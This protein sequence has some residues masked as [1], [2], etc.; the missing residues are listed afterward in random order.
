MKE[1]EVSIME[2]LERKV[3]IKADSKEAAEQLIRDE[4]FNSEH[5][6]D[7][8]DFKEVNFEVQ[9]ERKIN[10]DQLPKMDVLLIKPGMYPQA[11]QIGCELEDLQKVVG[12]DIEAIYPY[13]DLVAL[14]MNEEGKLMGSELNRALRDEDGNMYDIVAGDFLVVGLGEEDFDS[15]SPELMEKYEKQFHQPEMF[16]RMGRS[17]M[18]MPLPDDKVKKPDAPEKVPEMKPQKAT[19]DRDSL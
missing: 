1:Y 7:S 9:N 5:I 17:I 12:G 16:I 3:S 10:L 6:L 15:L 8:S 18:A 4:Y 2:T 19:P 11:V 14:V 13:D